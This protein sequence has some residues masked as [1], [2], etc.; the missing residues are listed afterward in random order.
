MLCW[1]SSRSPLFGMF[2]AQIALCTLDQ[3]YHPRWHHFRRSRTWSDTISAKESSRFSSKLKI[4]L[5]ELVHKIHGVV[6]AI[7]ICLVEILCQNLLNSPVIAFMNIRSRTSWLHIYLTPICNYRFRLLQLSSSLR[8]PS[9][10]SRL[11]SWRNGC[12]H[13][14]SID[15]ICES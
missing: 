14:G 3:P 7:I 4:Y 9:N 5:L 6:L 8:E 15:M 10:V 2:Q 12:C 13:V 1:P 11:Q